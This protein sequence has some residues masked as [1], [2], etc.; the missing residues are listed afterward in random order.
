[1]LVYFHFLRNE[2][3]IP[4][5][6]NSGRFR[7]SIRP[8]TDGI[9]FY[10][11]ISSQIAG[12]FGRHCVSCGVHSIGHQ[13]DYFALGFAFYQVF[14]GYCQP[15]AYGGSVGYIARL[16]FFYFGRNHLVVGGQRHSHKGFCGVDDQPEPVI[17]PL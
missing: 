6:I 17:F 10:P 4:K 16:H 12:N 3:Y 11:I 9:Y 5:T 14:G 1:M 15:F 13:N 7:V 2:I 8:N